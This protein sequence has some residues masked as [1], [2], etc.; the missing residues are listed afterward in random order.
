MNRSKNLQD[1]SK[2]LINLKRKFYRYRNGQVVELMSQGG[3]DHPV[4]YGLNHQNLLN[5]AAGM[6]KDQDLSEHLFLQSVREFQLLSFL[7][8]DYSVTDLEDIRKKLET[9]KH[10]EYIE[11]GV[12]Y[13]YESHPQAWKLC[14]LLMKSDY[15]YARM[16][17]NLL[18]ARL[19]QSVVYE[20]ENHPEFENEL[21]S[22]LQ[23]CVSFDRPLALAVAGW[24][25]LSEDNQ[26]K[27]PNILSLLRTSGE[28]S[29]LL[30]AEE[31]AT[32]MGV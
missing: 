15:T 23:E 7:L 13:G 9:V 12:R 4:S 32:R 30:M 1:Y 3:C 31:I 11:F 22:Q 16:A 24:L 25:N 10:L 29:L 5:I 19:S 18:L 26:Q 8:E 21:M 20:G 6:P 14:Q 28:R 2:V 27:L 17:G